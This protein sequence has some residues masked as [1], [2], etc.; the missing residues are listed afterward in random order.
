[1]NTIEFLKAFS[2]YRRKRT[3]LLETELTAAR[4]TNAIGFHR[5]AADVIDCD[6]IGQWPHLHQ[7]HESKVGPY[8]MGA[9]AA[10]VIGLVVAK[11][12]TEQAA[13]TSM[14]E[15]VL[16]ANPPTWKVGAF[17]VGAFL[18][19]GKM[20]EAYFNGFDRTRFLSR[21]HA[22]YAWSVIAV[23]SSGSVLVVA[24]VANGS[25]AA[26]LEVLEPYSWLGLEFSLLVAGALAWVAAE[27]FSWSRRFV[28]TDTM[29]QHSINEARQ[30]LVATPSGTADDLTG[31]EERTYGSPVQG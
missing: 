13:V 26:V 15:Q 12:I 3:E 20:F 30:K 27:R 4:H 1:M 14:A 5:E 17:A 21:A 2:T 16:G 31:S 23:A 6:P 8:R 9:A 29:F 11:Q 7:A 22:W 25:L 28:E 18:A 24:R 19:I 10:I